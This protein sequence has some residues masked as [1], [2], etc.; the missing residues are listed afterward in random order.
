MGAADDVVSEQRLFID[1]P[2][3][4]FQ[5]RKVKTW[6]FDDGSDAEG[7]TAGG[8]KG[9]AGVRYKEGGVEITL[10]V[11]EEQGKPEVDYDLHKRLKTKFNLTAQSTG[12]ERTQYQKCVIANKK[13]K[14]DDQGSHMFTVKVIA[15]T[16]PVPLA[17]QP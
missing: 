8:V 13:R 9:F 1:G 10:E 4:N 6:D 17:P 12:G 5:L 7:V 15:M 3:G 14:H 2:M 11:Y 16:G